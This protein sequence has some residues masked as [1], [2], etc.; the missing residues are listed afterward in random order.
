LKVA[1]DQFQDYQRDGWRIAEYFPE[2]GTPRRDGERAHRRDDRRVAEVAAEY[3][4]RVA[5]GDKAPVKATADLFGYSYGG[6]RKKLDAARE[7][8]ILTR[9][10]VGKA[11]AELTPE[12]KRLADV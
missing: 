4:K 3:A 10:S 5:A 11:G 7:R 2:L 1:R 9:T 12:G 6:V 8:E